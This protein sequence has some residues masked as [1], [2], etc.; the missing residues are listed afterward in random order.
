MI[1]GDLKHRGK[2]VAGRSAGGRRRPF[3]IRKIENEL[4]P[5]PGLPDDGFPDRVCCAPAHVHVVRPQFAEEGP[6]GSDSRQE[7]DEIFGA[8][9][10][11]VGLHPDREG[12]MDDVADLEPLRLE[13]GRQHSIEHRGFEIIIS[14]EDGEFLPLRQNVF[15]LSV[16]D[17]LDLMDDEIASI[18]LPGQND[19]AGGR[20]T[21]RLLD[22]HGPFHIIVGAVLAVTGLGT[23]EQWLEQ[24]IRPGRI[25]FRERNSLDPVGRRRF[26]RLVRCPCGRGNQDKKQ[27]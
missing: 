23:H 9:A 22:Q 2:G 15:R 5:G 20:E 3:R 10:Q 19:V 12:D 7:R 21:L 27:K 4:G 1:F 8:Q 13:H 11:G 14:S 18:G 24:R 25:G 17:D 26:D 6:T 16:T